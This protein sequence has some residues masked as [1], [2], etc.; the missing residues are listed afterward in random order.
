MP[1]PQFDYARKRIAQQ[2]TADEQGQQEALKRRF[3]AM[4]NVNSGAYVKQQAVAA[5]DAAKRREDALGG[6]DAQEAQE[7]QRRAEVTEGRDFARSE[8]V[9]SQ[10]FANTQRMGSQDFANSQRLGSQEYASGE[11]AL[12]RKYQTGE[13]LGSQDFANSQRLGSQEFATSERIGAQD[14]GT[15]ERVASQGWQ[16]GNIDNQL[17]LQRDSYNLEKEAQEFNK[18]MAILENTDTRYTGSLN[19]GNTTYSFW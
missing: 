18:T 16:Q 7:V 11:S 8:R 4:G 10:D 5:D 1:L 3:A 2:S 9:G 19:Y 13:R 6:V 14:Y 17:K 15:S 12:Q